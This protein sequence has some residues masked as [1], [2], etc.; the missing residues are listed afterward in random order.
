MFQRPHPSRGTLYIFEKLSTPAQC[1]PRSCSLFFKDGQWQSKNKP[2]IE[3][4]SVHAGYL[5]W[6]SRGIIPPQGREKVLNILHDFHPGIVKIKSLAGSY[7]WWPKR[8]KGE[9]MCYLPKPSKDPPYLPL[10][11]WEW[12][13]RPRSR[14]NVDYAALSWARFSC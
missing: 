10:L 5:L 4:L 13:G 8:M 9:K 7:V 12:P 1:F 6:G 3:E 11:P 14:V 2:R